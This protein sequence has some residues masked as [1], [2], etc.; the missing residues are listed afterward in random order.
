MDFHCKTVALGDRF[1]L[2]TR[3]D[4]WPVVFN[5]LSACKYQFIAA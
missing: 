4:I 2:K 1:T 3:P 5:K